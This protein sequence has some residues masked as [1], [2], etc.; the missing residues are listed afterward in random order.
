MPSSALA[1]SVPQGFVGAVADGPLFS[2]HVDLGKQLKKMVA[3][4]VERLRI[5]FDWSDAQPYRHWADVPPSQLSRF[6]D[7][8]GVPTD[9]GA[10]D[11]VVAAAAQ[12]HLAVLPVVLHA[13]R[14]DS[15]P[16]GNHFQPLHDGPYGNYLSGLVKRYGPGGT[17]WSANPSTPFWPIRTWQIWNEP[18]LRYYWGA[19][20]FAPSYV[21]LLRVAHK[22]I[23]A[24]DPSATVVLAALTNY[25]WKDLNAIYSVHGARH[26]FDTVASNPYT[27]DPRGVIKILGNVR[28][29]MNG[30]G[31]HAKRLIVTEVG[32]PAALGKTKQNFGFNTTDRGAA[33]KLS[34]LLP[35]LAS[36]RRRL[37]LGS[38]FYYT[39]MSSYRRGAVSW[40]FSGLLRFR[41][42]SDKVTKKPAFYSFRSAALKL[43]GCRSKGPTPFDCHR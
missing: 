3:S 18:E 14:W 37:G 6:T 30:H 23:K 17:F 36:N 19:S 43:E 12:R 26:L 24:A 28:R 38:F 41:Q 10:T 21:A 8:N 29:D 39:W 34:E 42:G 20:N 40:A 4:G 15:S 1:R 7:V 5:T 32:W 11:E 31:D 9:F 27:A 2:S 13:P 22:A 25:A 33:K 16:K 35:M